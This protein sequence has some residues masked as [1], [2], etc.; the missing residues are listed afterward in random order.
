MPKTIDH[1]DLLAKPGHDVHL[2]EFDPAFTSDFKDKHD[3][4]EKLH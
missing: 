1:A 4:K 3:A 2:A